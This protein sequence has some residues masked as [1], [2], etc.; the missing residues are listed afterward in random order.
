MKEY[1]IPVMQAE[2]EGPSLEAIKRI[3]EK[4]QATAEQMAKLAF[5]DEI[6]ADLIERRHWQ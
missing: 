3:R 2:D 1:G 4:M 6:E 5:A